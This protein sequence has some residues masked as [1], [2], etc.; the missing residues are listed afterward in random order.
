MKDL[1][2]LHSYNLKKTLFLSFS[3]LLC[4]FDVCCYL[5]RPVMVLVTRE[6]QCS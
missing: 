3:K 4:G 2:V 6:W 1:Q 5:P